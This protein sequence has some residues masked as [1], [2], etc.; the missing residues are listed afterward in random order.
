MTTKTQIY[1]VQRTTLMPSN[2]QVEVLLL[3]MSRGSDQLGGA[4]KM[5]CR[6]DETPTAGDRMIVTVEVDVQHKKI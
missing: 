5:Y 6:I 4:L 3:P 2:D 1:L